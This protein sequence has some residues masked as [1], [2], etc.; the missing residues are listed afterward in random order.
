MDRNKKSNKGV[1]KIS[2]II[3]GTSEK[4]YISDDEWS[5][6]VSGIP[7]ED[8]KREMEELNAKISGQ[9]TQPQ[10]DEE[11]KIAKDIEKARN[12]P[13]DDI[14]REQLVGDASDWELVADGGDPIK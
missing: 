2:P 13:Y 7:K 4:I 8:M 3:E 11:K 12:R 5:G 6:Y 10:T 9:S 14:M 1:G